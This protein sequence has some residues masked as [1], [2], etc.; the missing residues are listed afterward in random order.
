MRIPPAYSGFIGCRFAI[1][2]ARPERYS[3]GLWSD[4]ACYGA[5]FSCAGTG[6]PQLGV[7]QWVMV[8]M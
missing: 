5:S 7:K 2:F 1:W 8:W 4:A 3:P 6:K